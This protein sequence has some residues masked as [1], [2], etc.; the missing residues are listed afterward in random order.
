MLKKAINFIKKVLN[1]I[2]IFRRMDNRNAILGFLLK[3][4][5]NTDNKLDD[6]VINGLNK[7][8]KILDNLYEGDNDDKSLERASN[9]ITQN[10]EDFPGVKVGYDSKNSSFGLDVMGFDFNYSPQNGKFKFNKSISF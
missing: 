1:F 5:K 6:N 7:T 10:N 2:N 4:S 9:D 3:L 8:L